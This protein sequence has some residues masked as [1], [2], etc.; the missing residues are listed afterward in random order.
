M[1]CKISYK[2]IQNNLIYVINLTKDY[3]VYNQ[4]IPMKLN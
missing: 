2:P 4:T 3:T 1:F